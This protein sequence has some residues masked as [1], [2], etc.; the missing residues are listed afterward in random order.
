MA[1]KLDLVATDKAYYQP[2]S[3]PVLADFGR[4]PYLTITGRGAPAGDEFTRMAAALY[5]VAY[6]V[7]KRC[8]EEGRDFAVPKLEGLWWVDGDRLAQDVPREEWRWKLLIRLPDFPDEAAVAEVREAAFRS[9]K[10]PLIQ[11]VAFDWIEEGRCVQ[12]MHVGPYATEPV[13][14]DAMRQ[15]A[16]SQGLRFAGL[17]HE[18]YI[19]DPRKVEPDRMKTILRYPVAP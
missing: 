19:S 15:Y 11:E 2:T 1:Q 14:L 6:G 7:K 5:P 9:K 8:K 12:A 18:I 3:K 13:T 17:H 4:M 10:E 16:A